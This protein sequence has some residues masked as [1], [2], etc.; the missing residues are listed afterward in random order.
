MFISKEE[1]PS[2]FAFVI[3]KLQTFLFAALNAEKS[4][5]S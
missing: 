2:L 5:E 3:D 4:G 1:I